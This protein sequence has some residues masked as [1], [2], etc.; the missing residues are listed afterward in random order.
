MIEEGS[1]DL[2]VPVVQIGKHVAHVQKAS[3]VTRDDAPVDHL[4]ERLN[5]RTSVCAHT[6]S[7]FECCVRGRVDEKMNGEVQKKWRY[8]KSTRKECQSRSGAFSEL[9]K[10]RMPVCSG[11][12]S[13]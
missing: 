11:R 12:C 3:V 4:G 9:T 8:V 2:L 1:T 13:E 6:G 5:E 10:Y 7:T